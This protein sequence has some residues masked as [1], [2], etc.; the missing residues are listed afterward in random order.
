MGEEFWFLDV[1]GN[2]QGPVGKDEF[3]RLIRAGSISQ[4]TT[5]WAAGMADWQPAGQVDSL[6]SLFARTQ[7]PPRR[8]PP[9]V[10]AAPGSGNASARPRQAAENTDY[11]ETWPVLAVY[12]LYLV[13]FFTCVTAL[14]GV[15]IA[16]IQRDRADDISRTHFQFQIRTFWIGL[17]YLIIGGITAYVIVGMFV[18]A[19]WFIWTLVRC[20]KGILV[21]NAGEPI[22]KPTSWLFG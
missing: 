8:A 2:Q 19:W 12:I 9:P 21:F 1:E 6:S 20:V 16:Y 3:V 18:L 17:A 15:V 11:Q 5:I 4:R 22:R 14:I 10:M 7:P 13:G